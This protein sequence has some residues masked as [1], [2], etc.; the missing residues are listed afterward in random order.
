MISLIRIRWVRVDK[1]RDMQIKRLLI[2]VDAK[3]KG[4][5]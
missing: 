1:F 4:G 3:V 5:F 2:V